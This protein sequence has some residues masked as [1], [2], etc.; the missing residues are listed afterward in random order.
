MNGKRCSYGASCRFAHE[1]PSGA[2]FDTLLMPGP[3]SN[4]PTD[5]A[6]MPD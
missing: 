1:L 4:V 2:E 6:N 3:L 5:K